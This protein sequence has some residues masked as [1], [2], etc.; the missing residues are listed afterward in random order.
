MKRLDYWLNGPVSWVRRWWVCFVVG[1]AWMAGAQGTLEDY[2]RANGL[3]EQYRNKVFRLE[4]TPHWI[5]GSEKGWYRVRTGAKQ[6]EFVLFDG[7]TGARRPAF[8]PV[9]LAEDLTKALER[10][11]DPMNL[12]VERLAFDDHDRLSAFTLDGKRYQCSVE[13]GTIRGIE[14]DEPVR[15]ERRRS[16]RGGDRRRGAS[17][18]H[19]SPDGRWAVTV[20]DANLFLEN[21]ESGDVTQL[22]FE[23]NGQEG[24]RD[25]IYWAP[26][27]ERFMAIRRRAAQEHTVN[28]IESTPKDQLQPRL[29]AFDYLKPGD[30]VAMDHP[31]LFHVETKA[32][33]PIS[34]ALFANPYHLRGYRWTPDSREFH[35]VYNQRGH[36]VLRLVGI[37][38]ETGQVRSV[39]DEQSETFIDYAYKQFRHDLDE[40]EEVIWMSERSGWNHLYL[41]DR[42]TG[43][44]KHPITRG[45]WVVRSV[46][47]VDPEKRQI[48]F[49]ASGVY[50]GQDPY[51]R[52]AARVNFD[53]SGLT[54]L[55]A[56]KGTHRIHY[57]P[58]RETLLVTYSRV[59]LAP[60][61]ELRR[62]SDGGLIA[63]LERA[64]LEPLRAAGWI[65]PERFVA[66]GRD[67]E[68]DIYGVIYRP[69]NFRP[70]RTYPVIEHIYA[71]PHGSHVPKDF[72][73]YRSSQTTAELGFIVVRIDG[74]GTSNRSKAF[75]DVCWQNLKDAGFP[76][77]IAW[78]RAA[79]TQYESMDL[80]RV[81]IYGGSAGGQNTVSAL[82]HFPES[83]HVG[84][85]DCGCHDNRMDKIWWNELWMGWPIGPHYADNSNS[86][87][88][89]KLEGKL[90][91]TVGELDRNVDPASTLQL[92]DALV[93]ADKEFE[94]SM[95][96][97]A[98]HGVGD[99]LPYL[100]RKRQDYFVRHL[101]G[102]EPRQ[103]AGG[104]S[105]PDSVRH[106]F[107]L[108]S[109]YQRWID[110]DGF[111]IVS[112]ERVPD[113]ALAEAR[114]LIER[115]L[116]GRAD[117]RQALIDLK[118]RFSVM[119]HDEFTT[120]I[121]EHSDLTPK[122]FWDRRARGLG[123]TPSRPSVSCG[124]E[125]LLQYPGD[126]YHGENILIHEFAHA[127]H[128]AI[129]VIDPG[130]DDRL[131]AIFQAAMAKGLWKGK[132]ASTNRY[133][134][135]AECV[136]SYFDDNREND[137][138][139]NH[140]DTREELLVYD[141]AIHD[142]V[143]DVYRANPWRYV[144][145]KQ[146][147]E[148][149]H[150]TG[151]ACEEAPAFA[152]PAHLKDAL[153]RSRTGS[154]KRAEEVVW[155]E[156][157]G[158]RV[159]VDI[160][161]LEGFDEALGRRALALLKH[162]LFAIRLLMPEARL[163]ELQRV[164]I[165]IDRDNKTLKG[166]QYHPSK[167]WLVENGHDP[168]VARMVHIPQAEAYASRSLTAA[169]PWVI[170][171]ELAH[172][173]HDQVLGFDA[174]GILA[175]YQTAKASGR[176][177]SVGHIGGKPQR[178]YG[179]TDEK[180]YFAEGTEAYFG[181]NDFFPYVRSELEQHDPGLYEQL[182]AIW[183]AF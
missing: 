55:T 88:A 48:W 34:N 171:H 75:H 24:Y 16:G 32:H 41:Y 106:Q 30:Q 164:G 77:R 136:Q 156:I 182:E 1:L 79:A 35:F 74:M 65:T 132:Y 80:T 4:V 61:T 124:A 114:Y 140:V 51:Y 54:F 38:G 56:A 144:P 72:R 95:I 165:R 173:Y 131:E 102:V 121:P 174:E 149:G 162:H 142:L 40:T 20:R 49:Q 69:S 53:G 94:F 19:Q 175:A 99:G 137:Q 146:R 120:D 50:P 36:Q 176:Y 127:M 12:P 115:M 9:Q 76:D 172:A 112:S 10:D 126:P 37:H 96:P 23:G 122:D 139:H 39:I 93:K 138:S 82:L 27:S 155:Q 157:E 17:N 15:E 68:T 21:R 177:D 133:E 104:Q 92:V 153:K 22:S 179:M 108:N 5:E 169:Q 161:L 43:R 159:A 86:T 168:R 90:L 117:V 163:A 107:D 58:S 125:N 89:E 62:G 105:I 145:P 47:H 28:L 81:G 110:A 181:T 42:A 143:H 141:P 123:A 148:A 52:H 44:V 183:G 78:M 64:D 59:D 60:V 116:V 3:R 66:K 6:H 152:W 135:W 158:W 113:A 83:Y 103:P 63:V 119:A 130:F 170:L 46:D 25:A 178:H 111:P 85:A 33:I 98:G 87:H 160:Q 180:E 101:H 26:D 151:Y 18:N 118:F 84:V 97:G 67:G 71:G 13:G 128:E 7:K 100:I 11:F 73:A 150:L 167:E 31:Q 147:T 14:S 134:Y 2:E 109:F 70:D 8:D 57:S 129:R 166:I 154:G 29:H 45:E 91:L